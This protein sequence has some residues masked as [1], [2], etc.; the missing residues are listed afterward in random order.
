MKN[1]KNIDE[2][3][4]EKLQNFEAVPPE[5]V[6]GKVMAG[7]AT[8]PK[9]KFVIFWRLAGAAAI[10][11]IALLTGWQLEWFEGARK[12]EQPLVFQEQNERDRSAERNLANKTVTAETPESGQDLIQTKP[13]I[14]QEQLAAMLP[15][16]KIPATSG[17]KLESAP[18]AR[19]T[20]RETSNMQPLNRISG[21]LRQNSVA[22]KLAAAKNAVQN[23]L[24]SL[25]NSVDQFIIEQ[26][27]RVLMA[28]NSEQSKGSWSVGAQFSP[29]YS[30]SR[31]SHAGQYSSN[32]LNSSDSNPV[33]LGA[34]IA[35]QYKSGKRWSVQSGI[36][37][38]GL[39][40]NSGNSPQS[41]GKEYM[42][43]SANPGADYLNTAVNVDASLKTMQVNSV[44]GVIE[45]E[46]IP[47]QLVL[48]TS[49]ESKAMAS[50]VIVS[51]AQFTQSFEYIE[52]PL[53]LRYTLIDTR[54]DVEM[55][56]GFS[57]NLLVGNQTYLDD[58]TGK[59]LVGQTKDMQSLNYSGTLG[60]GLKYSLSK[61]LSLNIEP[62]IKYYLNSLNTN[63]AVSYKPYSFGVFSGIS[64]D[65]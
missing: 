25:G 37:Y 6:F 48:G 46:E 55:L 61:H 30:V 1:G 43:S 7:V 14:S 35:V 26:N 38:S 50:N 62:R 45:M 63:S 3:F 9:K 27:E 44:A 65:F 59:S 4:R 32:M 57:S 56:G 21:K 29:E 47:R 16:Q 22:E 60:I 13:A 51:D 54:I 20:F 39:A 49:I 40:Q 12:L 19:Q 2:L 36:Y 33:E 31:S 10:L 17:R 8:E 42:F 52:I 23:S 34:G 5:A 64:Y 15:E 28:Q 24:V 41:G 53:F 58:G 11:L 18:T